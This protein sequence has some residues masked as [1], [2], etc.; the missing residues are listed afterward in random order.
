[1]STKK[2]ITSIIRSS[3]HRDR[4][5]FVDGHGHDVG[6][7]RPQRGGDLS[8]ARRVDQHQLVRLRLL[9]D[10]P[11]DQRDLGRSGLVGVILPDVTDVG[12]VYEL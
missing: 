4:L 6:H 1:L 5:L 10:V 7:V 3:R 9:R 8:T 12:L 11:A 2:L